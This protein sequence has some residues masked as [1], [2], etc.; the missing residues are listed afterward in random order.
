ML[1]RVIE[2]SLG[3]SQGNSRGGAGGGEGGGQARLMGTLLRFCLGCQ[4]PRTSV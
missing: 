2:G 4:E 3:V 1:V